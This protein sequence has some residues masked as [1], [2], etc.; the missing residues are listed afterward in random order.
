MENTA[1]LLTPQSLKETPQP[2]APAAP[3]KPAKPAEP[4][5]I[6][7]PPE[8]ISELTELTEP[9]RAAHRSYRR[10]RSRIPL[11]H[12]LAA[13]AGAAAGVFLTVCAPA[14]TDF[15]QSLLCI[16]GDFLRL[17]T[18]RLLWG[19]AFLLAEYIIGYFALG[20]P[21]VWLAPL[22]C[23]L[24][25]GAALTG[26]FSTLGTEALKLIPTCVTTAAAVIL[27]AGTSGYMSSQLLR[28][29]S[30]GRNSITAAVSDYPP[31]G[32]YTLRFLIYFAVVAGSA[33]AEAAIRASSVS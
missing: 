26:A 20:A 22:V 30:S 25:T 24:G 2:P 8:E 15:S 1:L 10:R 14:G 11:L 4:P 33:I 3:A 6:T 32:E 5:E 31:A 12:T 29:M 9:P 28:L 23:G 21:L 17:M 18:A 16:P 13:A 19:T 7:L 27:G